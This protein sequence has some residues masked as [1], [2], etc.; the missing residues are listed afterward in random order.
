MLSA[1]KSNLATLP[2]PVVARHLGVYSV[3]VYDAA[4]MFSTT[5]NPFITPAPAPP[6][7][8]TN[9]TTA[10]IAATAGAASTFITTLFPADAATGAAVL[11]LLAK[12]DFASAQASEPDAFQLGQRIA[13]AVIQARQNDGFEITTKTPSSARYNPAQGLAARTTCSA[14]SLGLGVWQ[15][16][17]LPLNS[18]CFK[19]GANAV[20]PGTQYDK[21]TGPADTKVQNFAG[22][23]AANSVAFVTNG[24]DGKG[25]VPSVLVAGS[26]QFPKLMAAVLTESAT[27][28]D[29]KKAIAEFWAN[30]PDGTTPP[31][32]WFRIATDEVEKKAA[33]SLDAAVQIMLGVGLA[34]HD[35]GIGTWT[36]KVQTLAVRPITAIQCLYSGKKQAAWRGPY[37]GVGSRTLSDWQPYQP[38]NFITPPFSGYIS[39]HATFSGAAAQVLKRGFD[40]DDNFKRPGSNCFK[41][42]EG[43]SLIE[44]KVTSTSDPRYVKGYTDVPNKGF[45]TIGYAPATD[46]VLCYKTYTEMAQQA[47]DSRI[48][49]GIHIKPDND[50]GLKVGRYIGNK[51]W[52]KIM[53]LKRTTTATATAAVAAAAVDGLGTTGSEPVAPTTEAT[54]AGPSH[55]TVAVS[56]AAL[57][58]GTVADTASPD[59]TAESGGPAASDDVAATPGSP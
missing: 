15:P 30:G 10:Q 8:F 47:A 20:L 43:F 22:A 19:P 57:P 12:P 50:D 36:I 52:D 34:V 53:S 44:P 2:P 6:V 49:G 40:L 41:V 35:A 13:A 45:N 28:N 58:T 11:S 39:G 59:D 32:Q 54:E 7:T 33:G 4:T 51:V 46:I 16:L 14:L 31:G 56:D 29:S 17:R 1:I 23:A 18:S 9:R 3:A 5:L 27:L 25:L 37:M 42:P 24:L 21:L 48:Y 55:N 38:L 26:N